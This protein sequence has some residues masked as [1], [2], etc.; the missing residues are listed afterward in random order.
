MR[1]RKTMAWLLYGFAAV[2]LVGAAGPTTP[3]AR[4]PAAVEVKEF[5]FR[6]ATLT[7]TPGTT[8]SWV[9]D[10]EEPHTITSTD[11]AFASP[12]LEGD[13]R[14]SFTFTTPGT[15]QYFCALHPHMRAEV[16]VR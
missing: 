13:G 10:D 3:A 8:V 6:P 5:K 1:H 14:F 16:V 15:Y 4:A 2:A 11:G 12:P 7:V 9:N